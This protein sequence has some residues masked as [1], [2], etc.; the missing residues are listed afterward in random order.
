MLRPVRRLPLCLLLGLGLPGLFPVAARAAPLIKNLTTVEAG[1]EGSAWAFAETSDGTRV[2]GSHRLTLASGD[3]WEAVETPGAYAF[4]A[5]AVDERDRS[6]PSRIYAGAIGGIG[7]LER[8]TTGA[9]HWTSLRARYEADTGNPLDEVWACSITP[10]GPVFVTL[11]SVARWTGTRF[12]SWP[13]P[14]VPRLLPIP[15]TTS[16]GAGSDLWIYQSGAGLLRV[17]P[18]GPEQVIPDPALPGR[19]VLAAW[20]SPGSPSNIG[21]ITGEGAY[22]RQAGTWLR[23]EPLS[24][25]LA[26]KLPTGTTLLPDGSI[27]IGT[28]LDGVVIADR[29]GMVRKHLREADGLSD[30]S[31][32]RLHL[33]RDR[34]LWIG[35]T[36]SLAVIEA[37]GP[38]EHFAA[39]EGL[40]AGAQRIIATETQTWALS[41][42]SVHHLETATAER[43]A[44][45]ERLPALEALLWEGAAL[46]SGE[47]LVGG[48]GGVWSW[49]SGLWNRE[50]ASST[51][52]ALLLVSRRRPGWLYFTSAGQI[53]ALESR[54]AV[55]QAQRDSGQDEASAAAA[56]SSGSWIPR[57]LGQDTGDTP[58]AMVEDGAGELWISTEQRGVSRYRLDA[59]PGRTPRLVLLQHLRPGHE[60]PV[61][62]ER[63]SL[64][65]VGGR[66]GV[67]S[68]NPL[69]L[70]ASDRH[71]LAPQPELLRWNLQTASRELPDGSV[72]ALARPDGRDSTVVVRLTR[73]ESKIEVS[74]LGIPGLDR[75][76][77]IALTAVK[78]SSGNHLWISGANGVLSVQLDAL[79]A[80]SNPPATL[81]AA[82]T[83]ESGRRLPLLASDEQ[84]TPLLVDTLRL[85]FEFRA[86]PALED[87][88]RFA[89]RL[90]PVEKQWSE[91][92]ASTARDFTGLGGGHYV[93]AARA[94]DAQ[95]REGPA[96]E[97]AFAIARPWWM[98]GWAVAG[99]VLLCLASGAAAFSWRVRRLRRK[100]AELECLIADRTRELTLSNTAKSEFLENISHEIRNPLNGMVGLIGM[101]HESPLDART[102]TLA[103]S[104][105]SCAR[106]L[107]RAFDDVLG[108]SK[109]EYGQVTLTPRPFSPHA[110][111][112]DLV[113]VFR[114]SAAQRECE[115][116]V[117]VEAT[118]PRALVGDLEKIR[119]IAANFINN[120]LKYAPGAP[121]ELT[122]T[123]EA[124]EDNPGVHDANR[125]RPGPA[126]MFTLSVTDHGPGIPP[127]EQQ[128]I[129]KKFVR[130]SHAKKG[131]VSGTGLGLATCKALA[132]L[133]GGFVGV[134]SPSGSGSPDAPG[135]TFYLRLWLPAAADGEP[136]A[137]D[138][139]PGSPVEVMAKP[140][141]RALIVEDEAYNRIVSARIAE[142]LGYQADVASD[143][144]AAVALAARTEY[145]LVLLDWEL[146]TVK[147]SE[148][149]RQ[150]SRPAGTHGH[151]PIILATTAHDSD[152][153]R[154]ECLASGM[155]GFALKPFS[156]QTLQELIRTAR[157]HRQGTSGPIPTASGSDEPLDT[158]VFALVGGGGSGSDAVTAAFQ[159]L[160]TLA[161][162]TLTLRRALAKGDT[163][164]A[165]RTAHRLRSHAALVGAHSLRRAAAEMQETLERL[166]SGADHARLLGELERRSAIVHAQVRTWLDKAATRTAEPATAG[167]T[168]PGARD[169]TA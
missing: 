133:M 164:Q 106:A 161:N 143:A 84:A 17:G 33:G 122:L 134:E 163:E 142:Q 98:S 115:L 154:R 63:P 109:L 95:G 65:T 1:G 15:V 54:R 138:E 56:A 139:S 100:N 48:F 162:H 35:L 47:L 135:A 40:G 44:R 42:R 69:F 128:L 58:V 20:R 19:P 160:E 55:I 85:R 131:N 37:L 97:Y 105:G 151:P 123:G 74:P 25:V 80:P 83:N 118:V 9:W 72:L 124:A 112:D 129:F 39:R 121:L 153:I 149:A 132:E 5:L 49:S 89:T 67:F 125:D 147:G 75:I 78:T 76:G 114:A 155:E 64:L 51:D 3:R 6:L 137:R 66:V 52:T 59:A 111:A 41:H 77:S 82:V 107:T 169:E 27:A 99:G 113:G 126:V 14:A 110:L 36:R 31:V 13:L 34:R 43:S 117:S 86:V 166:D 146:G 10:E 152:A 28:L 30:D 12:E 46:D 104:L 22:F 140:G 73:V 127:D 68:R 168:R 32:H 2:L 93:F 8:D 159:Y 141:E 38:V 45:F 145:A 101:L 60:L 16:D 11:Q 103:D 26:G 4:R 90:S 18:T 81:L 24:S 79:P 119:T 108:F 88:V 150:L 70:F 116:R 87:S 167:Q 57:D 21:L 158:R 23:L 91:P 61:N 71:E 29:N 130:G 144:G 50:Y 148:V 136:G 53:R 92:Q 96:T 165:A 157:E 120:G 94:I 62:T 102:R 7:F 156:A